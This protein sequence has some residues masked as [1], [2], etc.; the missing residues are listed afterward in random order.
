MFLCKQMFPQFLE[1]QERKDLD[2]NCPYIS[3]SQTKIR[4]VCLSVVLFSVVRPKWT[5]YKDESVISESIV[6]AVV[7]SSVPTASTSLC[8]NLK[9]LSKIP[10]F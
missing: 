6:V 5:M 1:L 4:V 3:T 2:P 7:V 10:Y 9:Y 8:R